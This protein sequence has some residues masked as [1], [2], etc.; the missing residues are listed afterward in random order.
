[1]PGVQW[2]PARTG[3]CSG[4][5]ARQRQIPDSD[6]DPLSVADLISYQRARNAR[7]I[8]VTIVVL[9]SLTVGV[10]GAILPD[11]KVML[12]IGLLTFMSALATM[13]I[14]RGYRQ[15]GIIA[16]LAAQLTGHI[17]VVVA[18]GEVSIL[19][20]FAGVLVLLGAA[21]LSSFRIAWVF[22]LA[23]ATI[24]VETVVGVALGGTRDTMLGPVTGGVV[25]LVATTV[26]S[27]LHVREMERAMGL[28][29]ERDHRW[30][31]ASEEARA[32]EERHRLIADNTNDL[33]TLVDDR[34]RAEYLSPSYR[35]CLGHDLGPNASILDVV[36]PE[37]R[38]SFLSALR[39]AHEEGHATALLRLVR[40][41]HTT[42]TYEARL[43][44]VTR[45]HRDL[46]AV[47][48]RDVTLRLA[49][50]D[51]VR[52]SGRMEALDRLAGGIAHDF[53]NL[54]GVITGALDLVA[55]NPRAEAII[56][57]DLG[58]ITQALETTKGLTQ[59][60][61]TFS[62]K[63]VAAPQVFDPAADIKA[64]ADIIQR[65]VGKEIIVELVLSADCPW[66]KMSR[67]QL[68]QIVMNFAANARDAMSK[69]GK[70][71]LGIH[72]RELAPQEIVDLPAGTY[73][74]LVAS[75]T[76]TG[77]APEVVPHLFEPFFTTKPEGRG[78]GLGLATCYGI[79]RQWGGTILVETEAGAGSTFRV[80]LPATEAAPPSL[81]PDLTPTPLPEVQRVLL[82]DDDEAI[83]R[84]V[85]R[86]L[87]SAGFEVDTASTLPDAKRALGDPAKTFDVLVTDVVLGND[88]GTTLVPLARARWPK[89][90]VVVI[91]G[92]TPEP[93]TA[94]GVLDK[95]STFLAKPFD[96]RSLL[97]ALGHTST[98]T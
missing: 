22:A 2:P 61:L 82:V 50:E 58:I 10:V 49:L 51:Q 37:D 13:A 55:H 15:A 90:R 8:G 81:E 73:V 78:I 32:S 41:D 87:S 39:R 48:G 88:R 17:G 31:R 75:D 46:V 65:L 70:L 84:L 62:R 64:I 28:A 94:A 80:L 47:I 83:I 77:I 1:V 63:Q 57:D 95:R 16:L 53:N 74:E 19:P 52:K 18:L 44:R 60:L 30:Q 27:I 24:A 7:A 25:L 33:I 71:R 23:L 92:Y 9:D 91:S 72:K 79:A 14:L 97:A 40:T 93:E 86:M 5:V 67:S 43:S 56:R 96:R 45:E 6:A 42:P 26:I 20:L 11:L 29:Q 85:E 35:R 38:D 76:G 59:Q 36:H 34:G 66:V 98:D 89:I 21:T 68:E 69:A 3:V 12:A 4:P 54:L